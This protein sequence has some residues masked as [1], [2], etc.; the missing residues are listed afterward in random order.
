M[1]PTLV[2]SA[3]PK[4][5]AASVDAPATTNVPLTSAS[6]FISIV[7]ALISISVSDTKSNTPSA[8]WWVYC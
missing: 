3:S 8:D 2:I 7:V 6:P 1:F 5:V 4:E